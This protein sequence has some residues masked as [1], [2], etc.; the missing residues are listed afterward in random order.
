MQYIAECYQEDPES[1][2]KEVFALETLR[3]AAMRPGKDMAGVQKIKR[4][5]CQ[6]HSLQSRF[7]QI[8]ERGLFTFTWKDMYLN[9]VTEVTDLRYEMA[10]VL[11]NVAASHTQVG[12]SVT[13][14]DV[15][16]MKLSC[17]HFQVAAWSFGELKEKYTNISS[18]ADFMT[19]ELLVF[20]QQ[21]SFAQAQE[22]ILE[23]SLIDNR[24]PNIVAKVTAQIV[25]FYGAALA[26][27][28]TG[29]DDGPV[30]QVID[31]AIFKLWKK[32]VRFKICYLNCLLFLYQGQQAEE[33]QKMG[34]RVTLYQVRN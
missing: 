32:Y 10:A 34:E 9:N 4:Y 19:T 12:A 11:F 5:Y 8:S 7:P 14:G 18:G 6:L 25:M 2:S 23:K 24:K 3:N 27:L 22:C 33:K 20:M 30:S 28:L 31:K 17:T 29:G 16:G 26:A 15:E 1:Y 21:V 13:R